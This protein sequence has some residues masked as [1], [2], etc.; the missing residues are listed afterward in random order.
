MGE[1]QRFVT[2]PEIK[3]HKQF[4]ALYENFSTCYGTDQTVETQVFN[5]VSQEWP[6]DPH[7]FDGYVLTGSSSSAYEQLPWILKLKE[8]L[9]HLD[10]EEIR[11]CGICFGHQILAEALGGKVAKN[12]LGWELGQVEMQ[13]TNE[14]SPFFSKFAPN[15]SEE[16]RSTIN[17]LQIHQDQVVVVPEGMEVMAVTGLC[18]T[19]GLVKRSKRNPENYHIVS[20]QGHPEF[21]PVYLS[22]LITEL[23]GQKHITNEIKEKSIRSIGNNPD[24]QWFATMVNNFFKQS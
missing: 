5:A 19:Q 17:I 13:V 10:Q 3:N 20:F 22:E 21:N 1:V 7:A 14:V 6:E 23:V 24:Q 18:T 11:V 4:N 12:P 9:V 16:A 2:E 8:R 15:D